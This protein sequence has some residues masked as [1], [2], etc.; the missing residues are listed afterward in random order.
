M[1]RFGKLFIARVAL[2]GAAVVLPQVGYVQALPQ[3]ENFVR[4][5]VAV[6]ITGQ[7]QKRHEIFLPHA[8]VLLVRPNAPTVPVASS[9]TDLSGRFIIKTQQ[10]GIFL[11]CI[12]AE[13]FARTCIDKQFRTAGQVTN[14][15]TL[16]LPLPAVAGRT[17]AA[18]YGHVTLQDG[19]LAR[20]FAPFVDVNAYA[21][22]TMASRSGK[23]T[24]YV[25]NFGDYVVPALPVRE[26]FELRVQ[27]EQQ[28]DNRK[29]DP[30]TGMLPGHAYEIDF[31]LPNSAPRLRV[32]S[33]TQNGKPIQV[34]GPGS[35]INLHAVADDPNGDKLSYRWL[36]P[37]GSSVGPT[38]NPDLTYTVPGQRGKYAIS[39]VAGDRRGGYARNGI[40]VHADN[41]GVRFSG[42]VVDTHG[43]AINGALV[44]V[45]GR[46]VNANATGNF[47][48]TLPQDDRY[49]M[50]IRSPGVEAPNQQG[51]GTASYI[52]KAPIQGGRWALRRAQVTTADP[53][54]DISL[55]HRR[56]ERDCLGPATT[57][58]DWQAF[59]QPGFVQWQDG[60][61]NAIAPGDLGARDPKSVQQG[62]RLISSF[63][64]TMARV[65]SA[66]TGVKLQTSDTKYP[67]LPG[68]KVDIPANSLVDAT[69]G[70]APTGPVQLA[71]STVALTAGQMPGDYSASDSSNKA[72]SM[73]SFGAGSV[74]I[75]AGAA[76]YN[77]KPGAIATVTIP[78]DATQIV[79]GATLDPTMPFLVYD[80]AQGIWKQDGV[81]TL[82]GSG[83]SAAY[84]KKVTHFSTMN[85]DIFK[86]DGRA[87]VA[88]ELDPNANFTLPL[89]VEVTM[90][91]S[92]PN[93]NVIQVR[94]LTVDSTKSNVIYNLP[95]QSDIVL[96]PIVNGTLPDGSTGQIPAGVFV[97]NTGGPMTANSVP[98]P[99]NPDGTYYAE[100][101]GQPTGP[102]SARVTLTRLGPVTLSN[103]Q[104]F[105][106]GLYFESAKVDEFGAA[107]E[108]AID[109]GVIDYYNQAD[110]RQERASLNLFKS[111]NRFN[112]PP[113]A[114]E[115]EY[116]AQYANS[117]DLGFGRDM[118]CRRNAASDG[119]FDYACYVT[120]YGQPPANNPDQ[121]DADDTVD[122]SKL[123]DATVA[124]EYSRVENP[125][126]VSPEFP[127]NQRAV[128]FFVYVTQQPDGPPVRK[129]DLDGH[130]ARPVPQLCMVCHGGTASYTPADPANLAG[131]KVG[132]FASRNDILSMQAS[133]L[134][135]DLHFY[136]FPA[137]K[138]KASQQAAGSTVA[139]SGPDGFPIVSTAHALVAGGSRRPRI[140]LR[141]TGATDAVA[142][143]PEGR[144]V[145]RSHQGVE[146]DVCRAV[147]DTRVEFAQMRRRPLGLDQKLG[148]GTGRQGR[149]HIPPPAF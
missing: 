109:Q 93:P 64:P 77:L 47:S 37:D 126:N 102:C 31:V 121:Q 144:S 72:Q 91:P 89:Q 11:L 94:P 20:G 70:R 54:Q 28:S 119:Q 6:P 66:E 96:T 87:C 62:M 118:H 74:E 136:N 59:Q 45:N 116:Q 86:Q 129:A 42:V 36:L 24:G 97:V 12:E 92:K 44:E 139:P 117:G 138:S 43:Q 147:G 82:V 146:V 52:Y 113:A 1:W 90:Q 13:G 148:T 17:Q 115:V 145:V 108:A 38:G 128:K 46:I 104:E 19:S 103:G 9:L 110:P 41:S 5:M 75:G 4:G 134:P 141:L 133:F 98:P 143:A 49:V 76:R 53:T 114:G 125:P 39:V 57:R 71:L 18:A 3:R 127:D 81:A 137:S 100:S 56:D 65:V 33:A 83:T 123:P 78:V 140:S 80:E 105:L 2:L 69:S 8:G 23:Y 132:A 29:I 48:L 142:I 58:L 122:P 22:V 106:Q 73:E 35:T 27:I 124:M 26:V 61:G 149:R 40:V 135:F 111:K 30:Q 107:V 88:V 16:Y 51:F 50:N 101:N 60:R 7:D 25:N 32:L 79:G 55:Q 112:Q 10:S 85:S 14:V 34:V 15:R 95:Q 131:A 120:N 99:A 21:T 63:N 84:Q 68:I 67:C 130:G